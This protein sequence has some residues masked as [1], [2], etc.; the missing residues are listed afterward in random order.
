VTDPPQSPEPSDEAQV[1]DV[2]AALEPDAPTVSHP[3]AQQQQQPASD[4]TAVSPE[5]A[6]PEPEP[7]PVPEPE[8]L[9]PT[10]PPP[11]SRPPAWSP[12]ASGPQ[13]AVTGAAQDRPELAVGGAFA[14]GVVLALILKRLA[15]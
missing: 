1:S 8:K 12:P 13:P 2:P 10:S 7:E 15:R 3:P 9:S 5:P 11:A 6:V 14:G 4:E